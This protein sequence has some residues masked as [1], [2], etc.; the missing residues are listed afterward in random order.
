MDVPQEVTVVEMQPKVDIKKGHIDFSNVM[1]PPIS[2]RKT[3]KRKLLPVRQQSI[4]NSTLEKDELRLSSGLKFV[5]ANMSAEPE[6]YYVD[7][8]FNYKFD[9]KYEGWYDKWYPKMGNFEVP[10]YTQY[11]DIEGI[12]QLEYTRDKLAKYGLKDP[13]MRYGHKP[14]HRDDFFDWLAEYDHARD[15]PNQ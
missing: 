11:K 12:W 2:D 13:W 8:W 14:P 1:F 7:K 10:H 5:K 3:I 6:K 4:R 9:K 15:N